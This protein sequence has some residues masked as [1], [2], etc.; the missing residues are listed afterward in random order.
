MIFGR[1]TYLERYAYLTGIAPRIACKEM[2][3]MYAE[4][5]LISR[6]RL[7]S[8]TYIKYVL[9]HVLLDRIPGSASE[10]KSVA[11]TYS[12]KPQAFVLAKLLSCLQLEHV[13][14]VSPR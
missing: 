9:L 8:L 4:V 5:F 14:G 6:K 3:I 1:M 2:E 12:V 10:T 11:L 7:I 13:A